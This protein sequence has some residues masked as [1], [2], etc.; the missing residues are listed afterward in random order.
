MFVEEN[1]SI[2][3]LHFKEGNVALEDDIISQSQ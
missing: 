3:Q 1:W 2:A